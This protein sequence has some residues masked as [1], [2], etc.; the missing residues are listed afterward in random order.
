MTILELS[1]MGRCLKLFK[2]GPT[3]VPWLCLRSKTGNSVYVSSK[4]TDS[5]SVWG[6][7]GCGL[8]FSPGFVK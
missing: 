7:V 4:F 1:S 6:R 8:V 3:T 5:P 2:D